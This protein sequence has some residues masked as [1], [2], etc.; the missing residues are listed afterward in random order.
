MY[1][2]HHISML[3]PIVPKIY[4]ALTGKQFDPYQGNNVIGSSRLREGKNVV[5][6]A[7]FLPGVLENL[8]Q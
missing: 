4:K 3:F 7:R 8:F 6:G 1:A 2:R 5:K